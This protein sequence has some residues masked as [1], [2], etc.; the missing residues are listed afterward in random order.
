MVTSVL[1]HSSP[2]PPTHN[3]LPC[4]SSVRGYGEFSHSPPNCD[5]SPPV[6]LLW[7]QKIPSSG[8]TQYEKCRIFS[9][10]CKNCMLVFGISRIRLVFSRVRALATCVVMTLRRRVSKRKPEEAK[11]HQPL[12]YSTKFWEI[13]CATRF[14]CSGNNAYVTS[15]V[16]WS[17]PLTRNSIPSTRKL[18][19]GHSRR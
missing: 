19:L 12:G 3:A 2:H 8:S 11:M 7:N 4:N 5:S 14:A 15:T 10:S 17:G 9:Q 18:H 6:I 13:C 16:W 1:T